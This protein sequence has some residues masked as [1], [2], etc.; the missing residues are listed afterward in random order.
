MAVV[1]APTPSHFVSL[2]FVFFFSSSV[3]V[4][5]CRLAKTGFF[6]YFFRL[7]VGQG[8]IILKCLL[9]LWCRFI[10]S[11]PIYPPPRESFLLSTQNPLLVLASN[12]LFI[13]S[14]SLG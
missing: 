13:M 5:R 12:R 9:F 14:S 1:V 10:Y 2:S 3:L 8:L 11:L 4:L 7:R 6:L